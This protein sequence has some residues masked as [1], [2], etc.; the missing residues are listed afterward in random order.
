MKLAIL[1]LLFLLSLFVLTVFAQDSAAQENKTLT[2][3]EFSFSYPSNWRFVDKSST[4]TQQYNLVPP[5]GNVLIMIISYDAKTPTYEIFNQIRTQTSQSLADKL[6]ASFN[7]TGKGKRD[8]TC[9]TI[10]DIT[11]PGTRITGLYDKEPSTADIFYFALN[12]KFFNFIYLRNDKESSKSDIAWNNLLESF[13]FTKLNRKKPDFIL[14]N[15]SDLVLNGRA[16]KL[17]TPLFPSSYKSY[18]RETIEIKV[19]VII[20][21]TGK[22]ISAKGVSG[23]EKFFPY[24]ESAA[25]DSKFEPSLICGKPSKI[26]GFIVYNFETR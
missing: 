24:A 25:K 6:Y 18:R 17:A 3:S 4:G 9:T 5:S 21:E 26:S 1:K 23:N 12:Q 22:V 11:L 14:D 19:R 16:K 2:H 7:Q 13:T 20:D 8:E 15:G 10:E